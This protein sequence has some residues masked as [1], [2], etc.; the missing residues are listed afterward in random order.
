MQMNEFEPPMSEI[1][2]INRLTRSMK[3]SVTDLVVVRHS[4]G[5]EGL[6]GAWLLDFLAH[7]EA[8]CIYLVG[9]I[10]DGWQLKKRWYWPQ[11][12]NDVIQNCCARRARRAL[13]S[14]RQPRHV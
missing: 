6:S 8:G 10:I 5:H 7:N 4:F 3:S 1:N 12:H 14:S 2:E 11:A 13:S 9:D